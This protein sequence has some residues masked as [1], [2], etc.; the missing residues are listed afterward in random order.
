MERS[1]EKSAEPRRTR[2]SV[3]AATTGAQRPRRSGA[4]IVMP[5]IPTP[6]DGSPTTVPPAVERKP[7]LVQTRATDRQGTGS[8]R[9]VPAV[10]AIVLIHTVPNGERPPGP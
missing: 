5:P 9:A 1:T 3:G 8:S 6:P 2:R 4:A 10:L 7:R